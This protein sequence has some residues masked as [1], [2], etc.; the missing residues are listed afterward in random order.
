MTTHDCPG[1]S[2][3]TAP[4][5]EGQTKVSAH[6][7]HHRTTRQR[8]GPDDSIGVQ[9]SRLDVEGLPEDL[10]REQATEFV[11]KFLLKLAEGDWHRNLQS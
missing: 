7:H 4:H 2:L 8:A 1:D 6:D 11:E 3:R 10:T 5:Q 9:G